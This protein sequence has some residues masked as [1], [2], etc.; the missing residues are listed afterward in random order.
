MIAEFFFL[1][2]ILEYIFVD[3]MMLLGFFLKIMVLTSI[4]RYLFLE[5]HAGE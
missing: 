1:H 5:K 2:A 4:N 3:E